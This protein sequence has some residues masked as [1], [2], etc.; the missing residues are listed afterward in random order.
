MNLG[1]TYLLL[2]QPIKALELYL[3]AARIL[4]RA[5]DRFHLAHINH[6]MGMAYRRLQ[7]W[8]KA[9]EAYLLSIE[10]QQKLGNV[11]WLANTMDGLGLVYLEQE[12]PEKA[13]AT[14]EEALDWLAQ[15]EDEPGY[16]HL[17]EMVTE[18]LG[19]ASK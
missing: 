5:Q 14:F 12:Q 15:I 1:N 19:E 2:E 18:H 8:D 4:R 9:K 10:Q 17:F 6:N 3:P 7:E 13:R 11:A 16:E